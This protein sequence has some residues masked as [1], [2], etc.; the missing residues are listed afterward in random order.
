[1]CMDADS[2]CGGFLGL[3]VVG[4]WE[5]EVKNGVFFYFVKVGEV[6]ITLPR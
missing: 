2:G 4:V 1:M 5:D 3:G 6:G